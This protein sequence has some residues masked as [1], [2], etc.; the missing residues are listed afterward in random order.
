MKARQER[1]M[2]DPEIQNILSDPVMRQ[3]LSDMQ[4]DPKAAQVRLPPPS[5]RLYG[6]LTVHECP[7]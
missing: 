4:Q 6:H 5:S 1:A 3:V 2:A 7:S